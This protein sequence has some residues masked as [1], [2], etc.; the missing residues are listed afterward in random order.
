VGFAPSTAR[1]EANRAPRVEV[2]RGYRSGRRDL[3]LSGSRK[4]K[5]LG[6][7]AREGSEKFQR[8]TQS[9]GKKVPLQR[10]IESVEFQ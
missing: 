2:N 6:G 10:R 1:D 9:R 4:R 8:K 5:V 3:M 7:A